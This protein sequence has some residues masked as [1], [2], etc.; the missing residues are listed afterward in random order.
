[1]DSKSLGNLE[2][3]DELEPVQSL[4]SRLV[5][6]DF[7]ESRVDGWVGHDEAVDV[8]EREEASHRVHRRDD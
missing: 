2:E 7:R 6:V 4:G 5:A 1:M 8:G 3:P